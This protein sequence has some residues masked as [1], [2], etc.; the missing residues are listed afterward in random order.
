MSATATAT[1]A[2]AA[3]AA[4]LLLAVTLP[5]L[6]A[7]AGPPGALAQGEGGGVCTAW[8]CTAWIP[9]GGNT[10]VAL[11]RATPT[12]PTTSSCAGHPGLNLQG[13]GLYKLNP[14]DP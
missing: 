4:A 9:A 14:V 13:A 3:A 10:S 7:S 2:A 6:E 8:V 11:N 1:A 5:P 12:Q